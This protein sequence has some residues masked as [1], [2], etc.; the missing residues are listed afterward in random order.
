MEELQMA[1]VHGHGQNIYG[2]DFNIGTPK[3]EKAAPSLNK[4]T[5][6]LDPHT[7]SV[8]QK[9][10]T[11]EE[12]SD[13]VF[14]YAA[15]T[16]DANLTKVTKDNLKAVADKLG[17]KARMNP[18]STTAVA[19]NTEA[20]PTQEVTRPAAEAKPESKHVSNEPGTEANPLPNSIKKQAEATVGQWIQ[21]KKGPYQ[22]TANDIAWA[23]KQL[24]VRPSVATTDATASKSIVQSPTKVVDQFSDADAISAAANELNRRVGNRDYVN[25]NEGK[26]L[27]QKASLL[28]Q[29]YQVQTSLNKLRK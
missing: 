28:K 26:L 7:V 15:D 23:K 1:E 17:Y 20:E 19:V 14:N 4:P 27:S 10:Y 5:G 13:I 25:E 9:L 8:L 3:P 22:L 18:A 21:T 11:P 6:I 29:L 24:S 16:G 2:M 12:W